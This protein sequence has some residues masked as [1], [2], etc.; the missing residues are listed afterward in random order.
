[1]SSEHESDRASGAET[2]LRESAPD[3]PVWEILARWRAEGRR[4]AMA[5][6]IETRGFTPRKPGTRMLL[7]E[8]GET[9]GT[10]GGGADR[11]PE[12]SV[13]PGD[14][15]VAEAAR[16]QPERELALLGNAPDHAQ[17]QQR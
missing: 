4:F 11:E 8:D 14:L 16:P 1:M 12:R 10:I 9:A 6:V 15:G 2:D 17:E 13:E 7:A 3:P 5:T